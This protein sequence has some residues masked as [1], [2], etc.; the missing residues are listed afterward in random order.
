MADFKAI[1]FD[2]D[3]VIA[4]SI[5]IKT[6]A[7]AK[8]YSKYGTDV[9]KKVIQYHIDHGGVSRYEKFRYYHKNFLNKPIDEET[10]LEMADEFSGLVYDMVIQAPFVTDVDE[11][12][13]RYHNEFDMFIS[14][15]TPTAEV[16]SVAREKKIADYFT[17]IF[18]SPDKKTMHIET[19]LERYQFQPS[20][21][22]FIGDATTDRDAARETGITFIGRITNNDEIKKEKYQ[23]Q[24]F[25][26]FKDY[27]EKL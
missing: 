25:I 6:E 4:E 9:E 20:E 21:V 12:L 2:F 10:V 18:G 26:D 1:I 3:G 27:L 11:F 14:T 8:M 7:F 13:S 23:I 16:K 22:V 15:G 24:D 19:I 5:D 17:D